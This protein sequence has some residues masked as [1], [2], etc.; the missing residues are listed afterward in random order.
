TIDGKYVY[1]CGH[2][3]ELYC[4]DIETGKPVW[5]KN[6][7][8]DY[9]GGRFPVWAISQIPLVYGDMVYVL[10]Q[11]TDTGVVAFNKLTG[12]EVWKSPA[13]GETSY[14]SP[15]LVNVSGEDHI[16]IVISSTDPVMNRGAEMKKGCVVGFD[17][18]TG[19]K[20]WSYDEWMCIISCSP[21]TAAGDNKFL[22]VGGYDRG[23][24]MIQVDKAADGTY[25]VKELYT[26]VEFGDQTK[27]ALLID[28]HFYAQYG[29]NN[30]RDGLCCMD[31]DGNVLWKTK[32]DPNFDKGSMIYAD[33]LILATDGAN[34]LY[35]IEP[36]AEGFKPISKADLL[37]SE[38]GNAPRGAIG[39]WAPM[40]LADGLLLIRNQNTMKC[41][42]VTK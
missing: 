35:L 34:A 17:P 10:A 3:G 32:R 1:S 30:R 12:E 18:K 7:F 11:T 36:S 27:P 4:F 28:G 40:A 5:T 20:L 9:G 14:A 25:S 29:T 16:S 6:I 19:K 13:L 2:N 22:I 39:N 23:A 41:V 33:G 38:G 26:T 8:K 15:T 24:T 21:L 31:M 37:V 42:K